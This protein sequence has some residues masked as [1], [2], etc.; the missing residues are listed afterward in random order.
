MDKF[1]EL[2]S[3]LARGELD[4]DAVAARAATMRHAREDPDLAWLRDAGEPELL[5]ASLLAQLSDVLLVSG[6]LDSLHVQI[7]SVFQPPLPG[8]PYDRRDFWPDDY[9]EWLDE[10]VAPRGREVMMLGGNPDDKLTA[11]V[12]RRDDTARILALADELSL[13]VEKSTQRRYA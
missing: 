1:E 12:V 2:I 6:Q 5:Q 9:F 4:R 7:S 3:L 10:V 13:I 11:A 8:F